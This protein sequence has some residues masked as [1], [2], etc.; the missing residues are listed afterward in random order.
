MFLT[1]TPYAATVST[2]YQ[3]LYLVGIYLSRVSNFLYGFG[4]KKDSQWPFKDVDGL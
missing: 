1:H 2:C 4:L 3:C